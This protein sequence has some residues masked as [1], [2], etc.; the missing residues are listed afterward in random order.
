MCAVT[1]I[2]PTVIMNHLKVTS[3]AWQGNS[4]RAES[5]HGFN[6]TIKMKFTFSPQVSC[7]DAKGRRMS[8]RQPLVGRAKQCQRFSR[9]EC[10][11]CQDHKSDQ[12]CLPDQAQRTM[13]E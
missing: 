10:R 8:G 9:S 5:N 1:L 6:I 12:L 7:Y 3:S 13:S 2:G 4:I 11:T